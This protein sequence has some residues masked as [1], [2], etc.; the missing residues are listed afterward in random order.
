[1]VADPMTSRTHC[2]IV[3]NDAG[4][5]SVVDTGSIN[6]TMVNGCK[7]TGEV[8]LHPGDVVVIG[9]TILPWQNYGHSAKTPQ[10][11]GKRISRPVVYCIVGAVG[12]LLLICAGIGYYI[13]NH[14]KQ[15]AIELQNRQKAERERI[16]RHAAEEKRLQEE[17]K[18]LQNEADSLFQN[19]L[20]SQSEKNRKLAEAKQKEADEAKKRE[21]QA[22]EAKRDADTARQKAEQS[23][24]KA[25]KASQEAEQNSKR[26]IQQANEKAQ[27]AVT[28]ANEERDSANKKA[29]LTE[30]FYTALIGLSKNEAKQV[31]RQLKIEV[32]DNDKS[33]AKY[34]TLLKQRFNQSDNIGKQE[35]IDAI[36]S[37]ND[38]Q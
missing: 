5:Y 30:K 36:S 27:L 13:Y 31:C 29:E 7:I 1:V 25:L 23:E 4:E 32:P 11:L 24:Q 15:D 16:N 2:Q 22:R 18:R 12:I 34:T 10:T 28:A 21:K 6:G 38:K 19:A 14:R 8:R 9:H 17:A 20:V 35:I 26:A 33:E 37:K 3:I